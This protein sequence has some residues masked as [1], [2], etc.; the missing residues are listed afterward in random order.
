MIH[1]TV[2]IG[3]GTKI[4]SGVVIDELVTIGDNCFIGHNVVIRDRVFIGRGVTIGHL[5][6]IES[7]TTIGDMTTIQN[8][9]YITKGVTIGKMVFVGPCVVTTNEQHISKFR[10][11]MEQVL[12]GP[13]IGDYARIGARALILPGVKVGSHAMIGAGC[14]LTKDVDDYEKWVGPQAKCIG[15]VT[16][17]ET[18]LVK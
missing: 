6:S 11:L 1:E 17:E 18:V 16:K 13:V 14:V 12:E 15:K 9:C 5:C 8:Q 7:D 10:P 3:H 2:K 4:G